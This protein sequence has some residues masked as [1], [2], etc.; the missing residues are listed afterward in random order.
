MASVNDKEDEI[1]KNK[2]IVINKNSDNDGI[3]NMSDETI[4]FKSTEL[5]SDTNDINS[6]ITIL[7]SKNNKI[8]DEY[9][10]IKGSDTTQ[11][12]SDE[13]VRILQDIKYSNCN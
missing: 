2:T 13:E 10:G 7:M 3:H 11:L 9:D 4:G 12:L 5:L 6:A 1:L 8:E